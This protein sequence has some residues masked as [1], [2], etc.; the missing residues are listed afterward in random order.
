MTPEAAFGPATPAKMTANAVGRVT[1]AVSRAEELT[2]VPSVSR[3]LPATA[4]PRWATSLSRRVPPN[5]AM[6]NVA[7][8]PK[9]A[10]VAICRSPMTS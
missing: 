2:R 7:K 9:A 3:A 10:K 8:P 5:D 4:S 6:T 1:S